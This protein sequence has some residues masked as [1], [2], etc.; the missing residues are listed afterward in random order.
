[1]SDFRDR[2]GQSESSGRYGVV[3]RQGYTGKYQ[4][5]PDRI[6]DFMKSTGKKFS[7]EQFRRDPALQEQVQAWHEQDIMNYAM[8]NGLD[9]YF[10]RNVGGVQI[11]PE[12]LMGMAHLGGKYGM[13]KFLE[14]GGRYD[15]ADSNGTTLSDYGRK[16]SGSRSSTPASAQR[17]DPAVPQL[18]DNLRRAAEVLGSMPSDMVDPNM[19]AGIMAAIKARTG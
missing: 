15:P 1:M 6:S 11:T 2:L 4:F 12:A 8:D 9:Y 7:M 13:R 19:E 16:F 10:G 17:Q 5:G 18:P 3:N 14:T